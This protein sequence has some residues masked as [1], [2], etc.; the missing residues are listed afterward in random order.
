[1][2]ERWLSVEK[3]AAHLGV[4]WDTIYKWLVRKKMPAH[5]VGRLWKSL[6]PEVDAWVK[7]G[8]AAQVLP[9]PNHQ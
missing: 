1:M 8:K 9:D 5:K 4:N 6:A 2:Q 3:I 7:A